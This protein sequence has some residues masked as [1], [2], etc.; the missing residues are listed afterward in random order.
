MD[1][2][3]ARIGSAGLDQTR[4]RRA[5]YVMTVHAEKI[6]VFYL[7]VYGENFQHCLKKSDF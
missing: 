5:G 6:H 7:K 1:H 3:S 2:K 4:L